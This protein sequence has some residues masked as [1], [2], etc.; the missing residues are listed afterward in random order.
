MPSN[1]PS[2]DLIKA[3][4]VTAELCGRTFSEGAARV[5]VED[6]IAYPEHQV[7][8][9]LKRCRREVRGALTVQDVVSRLDDGRPGP[10]EAWA[11]IPK[12]EG[13]SVVWTAEMAD[14][15]GVARPLLAE[16]D[17]VAARVAF[18]ERYVRIVAEARDAGRPVDW[19]L[20]EGH[21]RR[22]VERV[23]R[24]AVDKGRLTLARGRQY[25]PAL[26]APSGQVA[27]LL[28]S[29]VKAIGVQP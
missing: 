5:F 17:L 12:D 25:V 18:R 7:L 15:L 1:E 22:G 3:V 20:S 24:E 2:T 13:T 9:A 26:P 14:A 8:A 27:A 23:V 21:D 11:M 29:A 6:L 19:T 10:E 16:G 4:A 28:G